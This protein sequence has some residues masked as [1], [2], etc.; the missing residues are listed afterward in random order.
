[1]A[2]RGELDIG[3]V[4]AARRDLQADQNQAVWL[5]GLHLLER[6]FTEF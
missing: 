6:A 2:A 1:M 3:Q 4:V 5:D